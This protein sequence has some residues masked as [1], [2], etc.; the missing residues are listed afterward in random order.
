M[1]HML[2]IKN[3]TYKDGNR[4]ILDV[5]AFNPVEKVDFTMTIKNN[6]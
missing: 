5:V 4:L 1:N 2:Y 3:I 6:E